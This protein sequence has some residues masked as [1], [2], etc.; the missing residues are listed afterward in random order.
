MVCNSRVALLVFLLTSYSVLSETNSLEVSL[1]AGFGHKVNGRFE[2]QLGRFRSNPNIP[3]FVN[4]SSSRSIENYEF[5]LGLHLWDSIKAGV[6]FGNTF[7]QKH[8]IQEYALDQYY[9]KLNNRFKT[10]YLFLMGYYT[11]FLPKRLS[12]DVGAGIGINQTIWKISGYSASLD[13]L[14]SQTGYLSGNGL[15]YRLEL[16]LKYRYT[17][18]VFFLLGLA[19]NYHT[20][21]SFQGSLNKEGGS[22]FIDSDGNI[23]PIT[24]KNQVDSLVYNNYV[25]YREI[26]MASAGIF[27]FLGSTYSID[28]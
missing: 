3:S 17:P 16:A 23:T 7:Y 8:T 25:Y 14:Q 28:F 6:L 13:G 10:E 19:Q 4:F 5:F 27:F 1:R 11:I 22:L 9:T 2:S 15:S 20:V 18:S 12:L 26:D 24:Q 21:P